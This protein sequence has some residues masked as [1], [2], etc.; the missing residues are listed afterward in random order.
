MY[1]SGSPSLYG[2]WTNLVLVYF[3]EVSPGLAFNSQ[4]ETYAKWVYDHVSTLQWHKDKRIIDKIKALLQKHPELE[5]CVTQQEGLR[6]QKPP[7]D[8]AWFNVYSIPG[9]GERFKKNEQ[10]LHHY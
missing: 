3:D 1:P 5:K 9:W 8:F 10:V 7:E 6:R 4:G 2:G